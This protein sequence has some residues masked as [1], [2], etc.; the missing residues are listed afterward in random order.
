M[1]IFWNV[2]VTHLVELVRGMTLG[3]PTCQ[4]LE[5]EYEPNLKLFAGQA[6]LA[7]C[8]PGFI[9]QWLNRF[10]QFQLDQRKGRAEEEWGLPPYPIISLRLRPIVILV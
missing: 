5:F 6:L 2:I 7:M 3:K 10:T 8:P 9:N 4:I 1:G